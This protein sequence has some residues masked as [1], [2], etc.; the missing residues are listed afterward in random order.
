MNS[1]LQAEEAIK[2]EL[3]DEVPL[4]NKTQVVATEQVL[5]Q[6]MTLKCSQ[7]FDLTSSVMQVDQFTAMRSGFLFNL[8]VN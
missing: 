8:W 4:E 3:I 7:S 1:N 6:L 2:E 5:V